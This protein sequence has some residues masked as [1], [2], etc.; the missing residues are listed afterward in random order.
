MSPPPS[1]P[2]ARL[3]PFGLVFGALAGERFPAI[4]QH[5]AQGALASTDR[6]GFVLLEPVGR[7][8]R[9]LVSAEEPAEALDG[10][11]RLLHHAYRHWAAGGWVYQVGPVPL[12]RVLAGRAG[13]ALSSHLAQ[14]ALYLQL[15][16]LRVWGTPAAGEAAEPL[17]GMF[18]TETGRTGGITVLG[19]F[20]L[21]A[22]R[23]GF[24]AVAV[25]GRA[26]PEDPAGDEIEVAAGREDGTPPFA[27][28][29]PGA[30]E[31]QLASL[32]NAGELLLLTCRLLAVLP[33]PAGAAGR[34]K[35]DPFGH[36]SSER[37]VVV[38]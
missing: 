9:E 24:S 29:L 35:R 7:L 28:R 25:E 4:A 14:P 18:V 13:A 10:H 5:L 23:P 34:G 21:R 38:A 22:D 1:P 3:T 30:R 31:A 26:D 37:F 8:L 32:A 15:P 27:P 2:P 19:V 20:G 17:D 16:E 6:D 33:P 12:E 11:V 36:D